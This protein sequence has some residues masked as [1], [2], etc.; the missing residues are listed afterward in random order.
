MFF[1]TQAS[2][3]GPLTS[4]TGVSWSLLQA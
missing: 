4:R 1:R 2:Q 3:L